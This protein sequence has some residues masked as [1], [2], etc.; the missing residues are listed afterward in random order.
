MVKTLIENCLDSFQF[1]I[2]LIRIN[3]KMNYFIVSKNMIPKKE[4]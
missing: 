2:L 4:N 3:N 1:Y